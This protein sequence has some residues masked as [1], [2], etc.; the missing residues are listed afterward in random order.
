MSRRP[1]HHRTLAI[2][3]L[4]SFA[5]PAACT[6]EPVAPFAT[7]DLSITA[8][9]AAK[10]TNLNVSS[11]N[12]SFGDQGTTID[13][14]VFGAGFTTGA[15]ATWLLHGAADPIHV[16]TNKTTVVS[17]TEL[18]ANI[19]IASD[20]Q[21]AFWDVQV[22]LIGG[23][24]GVGSDLFEVT[25]AQVLS[26]NSVE[27]VWSNNLLQVAGYSSGN[28]PFVIDEAQHFIDLGS[29]QA[30]GLDPDGSI[31]VGRD[32][33]QHAMSWV[34]QSDGSW[35]AQPLPPAPNSVEQNVTSAARTSSGT[36]LAAGW[37]GTSAG[38]FNTPYNRPV[39]WQRVGTSWS[40]PTIYVYPPGAQR[41][42]AHTINGLGQIAGNVDNSGIGAV[43]DNPT[44]VTRL[45]GL[46]DAINS[47]GTL[48]VGDRPSGSTTIPVY[49]YR[50]PATGLWNPT[51][52]PLP[53]SAGATCASGEA[54][55]LND[56]GIIVGESCNGDG[57]NQATVWRLDLSSGTPTVVGTATL[58]PGLGAKAPS[59]AISSATGVNQTA[60][61]VVSGSA[62]TSGFH[63]LVVQW[64]IVAP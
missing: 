56:A 53:M 61:Y 34:R 48:I 28:E 41:A 10:S 5:L 38:K 49:W 47:T 39:V 64:H 6:R 50:D 27:E 33:G 55:G 37:D 42:G 51:G 46:P 9:V 23:K 60:P 36:L 12:P 54:R 4:L 57:K 59:G 26:S 62:T 22:A 11:A 13:V 29:G 21:L 40:A 15:Q 18:V 19:T 44:T 20:A 25:T 1:H 43:W 31:A 2:A 14:H 16:R 17:S 7:R 3:G 35:Q 32:G 45:D 58:L 30:W 24:N 52:V 8:A 63:R